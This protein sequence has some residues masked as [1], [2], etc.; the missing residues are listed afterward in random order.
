VSR[1]TYA[2]CEHRFEVTLC[3]TC[4][5]SWCAECDPAPSALCH[6]CHGRGYSHASVALP[7]YRP[8]YREEI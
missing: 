1:S 7:A 3:L 5:G 4:Y 6:W 8:T 2:T